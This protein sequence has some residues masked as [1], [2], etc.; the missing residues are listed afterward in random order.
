VKQSAG[1]LLYK[2]REAELLV[3]LAHPGG[4]FFKNKDEGAWTIPKGE[5]AEGQDPLCEAIREFREETG[6]DIKGEFVKL[7]PVRSRSGKII[8][9][10]A[11]SS[12][13]E[14]VFISSNTFDLEWP[15]KSGSMRSFPEIDKGA[16]FTMTEA[17]KKINASQVPILEQLN[18]LLKKR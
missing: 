16:W 12:E 2:F 8:H 17:K 9:T 10:W 13:L 15:P 5:F 11:V 4:P 18:A 3:F 6:T 7:A 14:Q 1:I